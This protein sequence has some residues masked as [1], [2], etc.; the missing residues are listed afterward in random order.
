MGFP[1]RKIISLCK[2]V[3]DLHPIDILTGVVGASPALWYFRYIASIFLTL[4]KCLWS[5]VTTRLGSP[6]LFRFKCQLKLD[7][8][9][10]WLPES[11]LLLINNRFNEFILKRITINLNV[12]PLPFSMFYCLLKF[13]WKV[14]QNTK[15]TQVCYKN[16]VE[17]GKKAE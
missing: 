9:H 17:M 15:F 5:V 7:N 8:I 4:H 12:P 14:G 3:S 13:V 6:T 10:H 2:L 1:W 11:H 16:N